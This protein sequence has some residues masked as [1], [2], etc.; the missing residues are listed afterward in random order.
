MSSHKPQS[1]DSDSFNRTTYMVEYE[2]DGVR[3]KEFRS[4]DVT[5]GKGNFLAPLGIKLSLIHI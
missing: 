2:I 4:L 3:Y 5:P 1:P